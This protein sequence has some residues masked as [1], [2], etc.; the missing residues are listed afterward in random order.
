MCLAVDDSSDQELLRVIGFENKEDITPTQWQQAHLP[1]SMAGLGIPPT[2]SI[3]E[4]AFLASFIAVSRSVDVSQSTCSASLS[5]SLQPAIQNYN[6]LVAEKDKISAEAV[7]AGAVQSKALRQR[8]LM[9]RVYRHS[10]DSMMRDESLSKTDWGR[11][12]SGTAYQFVHRIYPSPLHVIGGFDLGPSMMYYDGESLW[13][14][15][16][17]AFCIA[18]AVI[19][20]DVSRRS[21]TYEAR[22]AKYVLKKKVGLVLCNTTAKSV[23]QHVVEQLGDI[24][25]PGSEECCV[26][27]VRNLEVRVNIRNAKQFVKGVGNH[28]ID[29][30]LEVIDSSSARFESD[31]G[32]R[33]QSAAH[34]GDIEAYNI[35]LAAKGQ[36]SFMTWKYDDGKKVFPSHMSKVKNL[37]L[38]RGQK[39]FLTPSGLKHWWPRMDHGLSSR[40]LDM[41]GY[42][43]TK[44]EMDPLIDQLYA[45]AQRADDYFATNPGIKWITDSPGR[46]WTA[47][48]NPILSAGD[49]YHKSFRNPLKIGIP[50]D[51]YCLLQCAQRKKQGVFVF[52]NKD[53]LGLICQWLSRLMAK[54]GAE[55]CLGTR[56]IQWRRQ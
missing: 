36:F 56:H 9:G 19:I 44:E 33:W 3:K 25:I 50:D 6:M 11:I 49:W 15:P 26:Q 47:S 24:R 55:R 39:G 42:T 43:F 7:L 35:R 40:K 20:G 23:V 34:Y 27:I 14:T 37:H 41:G 18:S 5:N 48:F 54:D 17:G 32:L 10:F 45:S 31:Y 16:F 13:T 46:Q 1:M 28:A 21:T 2:V 8:E 4:A 22:I 51:V 29:D 52:L 30:V 53:T 12:I 38:V